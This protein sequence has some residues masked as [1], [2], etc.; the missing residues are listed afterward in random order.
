[1]EN[2][3][4]RDGGYSKGIFSYAQGNKPQRDSERARNQSH[5]REQQKGEIPAWDVPILADQC[6]GI[7]ANTE[8]HGV[9]NGNIAGIA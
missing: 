6:K 8:I 4:E 9:A 2:E 3:H 5:Q 7:G 1:M